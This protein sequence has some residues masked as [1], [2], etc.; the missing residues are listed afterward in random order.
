LYL[1]ISWN[2]TPNLLYTLLGCVIFK[3]MKFYLYDVDKG[4][5]YKLSLKS[6]VEKLLKLHPNWRDADE[7]EMKQVKEYFK[8]YGQVVASDATNTVRATY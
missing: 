8:K 6:R 7:D 1:Y 3:I 5:L 4:F 2:D